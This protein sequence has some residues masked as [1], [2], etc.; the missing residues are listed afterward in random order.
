MQKVWRASLI[1]GVMV[2]L[3]SCG[4]H[5]QRAMYLAKPLHRMYLKTPDPYGQLARSLQQYLKISNVYLASSPEEATTVLSILRDDTSQELLSVSGTQ[6]TRQYTLRVTVDFAL[7]TSDG[8]MIG[9]PQTLTETRT[10]T[11]QSNQILGS[12]NEANLF[13]QQMRRTIAYA[14]LNRISSN[15]VTRAVD[16]AFLPTSPSA[17]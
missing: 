12:S 3:T 11:V 2:F 13:Y 5:L 10:M 9:G 8:K 4:F 16:E 14:I 17:T 6:Q 7:T 15:E 1:I